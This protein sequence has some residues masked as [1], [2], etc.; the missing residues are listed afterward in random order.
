MIRIPYGISNFETL[1]S[2]NYHYVDRTPYISKLEA[3]G[4][5]YLFLVRPRRFGKSLF[6]STLHYYYGLEHKDKFQQ[7]FGKYYIGQYPTPSAN[8]YLVLSLSFSSIH[9]DTA[10]TTYRDFLRNIQFGVQTLMSKFPEWFD[11]T[12][13]SQ[14]AELDSPSSVIQHLIKVIKTKD[15]PAKLYI[16]IDE[17]DH[18]ANELLAF[19]FSNFKNIVSKNGYVRKFYEA[20]KEGTHLGI[21][22]RMFITGVTPITLDSLTSGFNISAKLTTDIRFNELFGFT[23]EEVVA[24]LKGINLTESAIP[25]TMQELTFWYNGYLFNKR[26]KSR[27]YNPDM[28]FYLSLIHI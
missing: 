14:V 19:D 16:L 25:A 18:F 17:Y 22:D 3:L 20:L 9:T 6:V 4:E 8:S 26:A 15:I 2:E 21:I 1:V 10:E 24:V 12:S 27:I 11:L 13:I 23:E 28:I 7:L 5:R